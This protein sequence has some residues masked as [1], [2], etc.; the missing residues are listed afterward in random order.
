MLNQ[1]DVAVQHISH[2]KY[3][4]ER[5]KPFHGSLGF[6]GTLLARAQLP[7]RRSLCPCGGDSSFRRASAI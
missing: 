3:L 4:E 5:W 6:D 1:A 7:G 2:T